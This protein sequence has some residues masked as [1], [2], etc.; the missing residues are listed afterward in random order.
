MNLP[1]EQGK[2]ALVIADFLLRP[3]KAGMTTL[4]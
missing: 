2:F 4:R 1:V 3:R